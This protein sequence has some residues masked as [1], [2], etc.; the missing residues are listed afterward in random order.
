MILYGWGSNRGPG[1]M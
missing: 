1:G